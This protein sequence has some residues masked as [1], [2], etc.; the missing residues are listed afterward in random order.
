MT[1]KLSSFKALLL[2]A[3]LLL[4][5]AA[6]G[7]AE[8]SPETLARQVK[9][10]YI[11]KF[12]NYI[13]WPQPF[14]TQASPIVIGVVGSENMAT[15]LTRISQGRLINGRP[16]EVRQLNIKESIGK[17]HILYVS[18]KTADPEINQWLAS[19]EGQ[20]ILTVA[21]INSEI[22][23]NTVIKFILE[24]NRIRFDISLIEAEKNRIRI[25]AP[26][27]TVARKIDK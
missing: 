25:T 8:D 15:E 9:A 2:A 18:N 4:G 16:V 11:F 22:A 5:H 26:L 7:H 1:L 10:A 3:M 6:L 20:P 23:A 14:E 19:L 27:L 17:V 13:E 24:N 21:D 12:A